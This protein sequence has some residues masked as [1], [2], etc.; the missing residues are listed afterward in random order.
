MEKKNKIIKNNE[1][2]VQNLRLIVQVLFVL[3]CVWIGYE[4]HLFVKFLES[5]GNSAFY[6]RP[7]GVDGFLPISSFMSFFIFLKTGLLAML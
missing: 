7:P 3:L 5:G 2:P 6:S 4:F 1:K